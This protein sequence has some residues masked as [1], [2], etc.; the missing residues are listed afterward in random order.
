M[1]CTLLVA[2]I[3][4]K[5]AQ[6]GIA[7]RR[8]R[9]VIN[10][11]MVA[12]ELMAPTPNCITPAHSLVLQVISIYCIYDVMCT[13]MLVLTARVLIAMQVCIK[14]QM[15]DMAVNFMAQHEILE[16]NV[17]ATALQSADFLQYFYYSG[18]W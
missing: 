2:K 14:G 9:A 15:Y 8:P 3:A 12:A 5:V 6:V 16:V 18:I 11:L 7:I 1:L 13:W 4:R 17:K 10:L